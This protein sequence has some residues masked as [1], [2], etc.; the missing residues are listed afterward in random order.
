M[1]WIHDAKPLDTADFDYER[2]CVRMFERGVS[3]YM[4]MV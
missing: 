4:Q 2:A 1:I 3:F